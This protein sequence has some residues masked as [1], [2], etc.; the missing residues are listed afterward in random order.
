MIAMTY[1]GLFKSELVYEMANLLRG[2]LDAL[3]HEKKQSVFAVFIEMVNNVLM[4]SEEKESGFAK[5]SFF[6]NEQNGEFCMQTDNSVTNER[7][8]FLKNKIAVL[9]EM[10]KTELL[11]VYKEGAKSKNETGKGAGIGLYEIAW[12]A[13]SKIE[14]ELSP[15]KNGM[16]NFKM[17]VTI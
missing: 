3:P 7:A 12:R 2:Q 17:Y 16:M 9:N 14:Y 4:H 6:L 5:G 1:G 11:R 13:S 15:H 8:D 10:E